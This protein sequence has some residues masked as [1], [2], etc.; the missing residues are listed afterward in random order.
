MSVL[1]ARTPGVCGEFVKPEGESKKIWTPVK[2]EYDELATELGV[3][4]G[5]LRALV[6]NGRASM[7]VELASRGL[8]PM[9]KIE[10]GLCERIEAARGKLVAYG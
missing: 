4:A 6:K 10:Y 1:M 7:T 8:L 2:V 9:P 5:D 3:T